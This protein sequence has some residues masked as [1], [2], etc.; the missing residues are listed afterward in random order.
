MFKIR[1]LLPLA[2][3]AAVLSY[4]EPSSAETIIDEWQ[5]VKAGQFVCCPGLDEM[6]FRKDRR[7]QAV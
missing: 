7:V 3:L 2:A 4:A 6:E 5:S 1:H